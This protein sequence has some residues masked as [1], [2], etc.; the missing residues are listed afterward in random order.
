M[1][2]VLKIVLLLSGLFFF[3]LPVPS[4]ILN[5]IQDPTIKGMVLK[6][7]L[8]LNKGSLQGERV[9][10]GWMLNQVQHD[11]DSAQGIFCLMINI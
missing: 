5:L 1:F 7:H 10:L 2:R 6:K 11:C 3:A 8:R 4:V 9:S